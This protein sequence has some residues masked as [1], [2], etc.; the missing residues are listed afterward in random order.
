[1]PPAFAGHVKGGWRDATEAPLLILLASLCAAR[2]DAAGGDKVRIVTG[3]GVLSR[4][5]AGTP[6]AFSVQRC[7]KRVGTAGRLVF[8]FAPDAQCAHLNLRVITSR[9]AVSSVPVPS[10]PA[11]WG[12]VSGR[13]AETA[14]AMA[15]ARTV[16][17]VQHNLLVT[18]TL[19]LFEAC[20]AAL[21][22]A[23]PAARLGLQ[24]RV[25]PS[26]L[27]KGKVWKVHFWTTEDGGQS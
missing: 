10:P 21:E 18:F 14:K 19:H 22:A 7:H 3:T 5:A 6:D 25:L 24:V 11:D 20:R 4:L 2:A 12:R 27:A 8:L 26:L 13:A 9:L 16:A 23:G 15:L 1:M 17:C